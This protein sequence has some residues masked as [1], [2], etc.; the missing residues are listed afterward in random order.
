MAVLVVPVRAAASNEE[1]RYALRSWCLNLPHAAVWLV[2]YQPHWVSDGVGH[3][4]TEQV[5]LSPWE[6]TSVAMRAACEHPGIPE[7]FVWLDDDTFAVRPVERVPA[8]HRGRLRDVA[9][10]RAVSAARVVDEY[11]PQLAAAANQLEGLGYAEPLC[12][13]MHVPMTI[14]KTT[15][16]Q[17][18]EVAAGVDAAKRSVYG[19]LA[20]LGGEQADDVKVSWRAPR[21]YGPQSDFVSTA[22]DAFTNGHV[23]RWI[24]AMFPNRCR[25]EKRG[26]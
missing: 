1:L 20:G 8:V 5:G 23:G 14:R 4:P 21:G 25:Y 12:Y 10:G 13:E 26:H 18:L 11:G 6:A 17:A 9:A 15:M 2:G 16:L 7:E 19:A 22:P 24:R 3:I